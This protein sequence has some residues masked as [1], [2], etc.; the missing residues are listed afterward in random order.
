MRFML[1]NMILIG[2]SLWERDYS[3]SLQLAFGFGV[4]ITE[5]CLHQKY[6][7]NEAGKNLTS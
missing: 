2:P 5:I 7:N 6:I 1:L 4:F 3:T